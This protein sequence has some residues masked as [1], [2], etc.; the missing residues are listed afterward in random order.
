MA[1]AAVVTGGFGLVGSETVKQLAAAGRRVV[2]ADLDTPANRKKV[3]ALPVGVDV[4]W[5]DLTNADDV[6]RLVSAVQ[7]A[8]I[9]HLAAIIPPPLYKNPSLARKVNVDA[10][11]ALVRA[12]EALPNPPRFVQ[13]S[14][15]AVYGS[16][17]PHRV[18]DVVR[19]DTPPRP[20]EL[21]SNT[22]FQ[23]EQNVRNSSLPWVVLR[24]GGVLS[25]NFSALPLTADGIL[26]ESALPTDGR[27]HT[28]DVRDVGVAFAAAT[29]ADVIGEILLI[30]GD[31]SHKLLQKDVGP[32]LAAAL[33]LPGVIPE[34][35]K[36]DPDDDDSWFLTDWM[37]TARA[38]EALQF[39]NHS[40]QAM[41][42]EMSERMG[43]KRLLLRLVAPAARIFLAHRAAYRNAPGTYADPWGAVAARLGDPCL[44]RQP[45]DS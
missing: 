25:P 6:D 20:F 14:S 42:A 27:I 40:W 34:G 43:W 33:G 18:T 7:P 8:V 24:L 38:Q 3:A 29:T 9:V 15:N 35:R 4:R 11:V 36:G 16:R 37:D 22:K 19:A 10:T 5:T 39:Q 45:T 23:A 2:V 17:N 26:F 21:Y 44:E 28:V 30:A 32:A 41:L 13:A 12:A 1:D 31:D